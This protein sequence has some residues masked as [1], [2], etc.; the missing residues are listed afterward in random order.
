[1]RGRG[2]CNSTKLTGWDF[3]N[4]GFA[5]RSSNDQVVD[6]GVGGG[7]GQINPSWPNVLTLQLV[8]LTPQDQIGQLQGTISA[9]PGLGGSEACPTHRG[10]PARPGPGQVLMSLYNRDHNPS[11]SYSPYRPCSVGPCR[12][13]QHCSN[14]AAPLQGLCKDLIRWSGIFHSISSCSRAGKPDRCPP[15]AL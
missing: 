9:I 7:C 12:L 3:Y 15:G 8:Y 6:L 2:G 5:Q 14:I 11:P 1:M 10:A 4:V 13:Q